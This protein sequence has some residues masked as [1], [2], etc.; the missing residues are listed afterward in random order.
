MIAHLPASP[1]GFPDPESA[2][3]DGLLAV[4]GDL[5]PPW[6][7]TAYYHGIFPWYSEGD[8]IL[9]WATNPRW[10]ITPEALRINRTLRKLLRKQAYQIR[11]NQ[12]F[13]QVIQACA[14]PRDG[15][16]GTWITDDMQAAYIRLHELGYAHSIEVWQNEALVGGLYG[17]ALG[18]VFFGESMFSRAPSASKVALVALAKQS[19]VKLIDCQA[20]THHT[21]S[22][23]A[24]AMARSDFRA[25]LS[26]YIPLPLAPTAV[27]F[28][29]ENSFNRATSL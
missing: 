29:D 3:P 21:E 1:V 19:W 5:T 6:L 7:L 11:V 18:D 25:L 10:V 20:H 13:S 12:A 2:T 16:P 24:I 14:E 17:I 9:W 8:P 4:G 26:T 22:L 27:K 15:Q 23:G 28:A